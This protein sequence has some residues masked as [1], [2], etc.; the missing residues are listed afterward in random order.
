MICRLSGREGRTSRVIR[1]PMRLEMRE[2]DRSWV[3][4]PPVPSPPDR[5]Y[6]SNCK[7]GKRNVSLLNTHC[8]RCRRR[9]ARSMDARTS[10]SAPLI[11][12]GRSQP[13]TLALGIFD[14][15]GRCPHDEPWLSRPGLSR[16]DAAGEWPQDL[17]GGD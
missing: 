4:V 13:R 10:P 6:V 7:R 17:A 3:Q 16:D 14:P 5:T 9:S 11:P 12:G 2:D 15:H 8:Q 1:L